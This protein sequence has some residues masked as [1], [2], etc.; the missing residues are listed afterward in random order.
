M[1]T[2][3]DLAAWQ[4]TYEPPVT[5]DYGGLTVCKTGPWGQ[6]PVFLPQ[7]ALLRGFDLRGDGH[8]G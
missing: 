7:L 6:G 1:L 3:D 5:L 2:G 8:R 4:S